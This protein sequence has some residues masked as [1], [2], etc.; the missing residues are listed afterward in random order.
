[1]GRP[2]L[3]RLAFRR[4]ILSFLID[5]VLPQGRVSLLGGVSDVGK[6]SF[7]LPLLLEWEQGKP[8]LSKPSH[9]VPWAYVSGDRLLQDAHDKLNQLGIPKTAIRMIPASGR[10]HKGWL[11]ILFA[12]ARLVPRPE[13]LVVE[14]FSEMC[15]ESRAE[16]ITHLEETGAMCQGCQ[17]F[18]T[19]LTV[20]GIVE[21]PKQKPYE[22]YPNPRQRISGSSAW[23]YK[24]STVLLL[25]SVK[26]D[27]ELLT[28]RRVL[29]V[30][31]KIGKRRKLDAQF[32]AVGR[33]IV[34]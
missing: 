29:Y 13:F 11:S 14:G 15:G 7:I 27:E 20:L 8:V 12:A 30:C 33:L 22:R 31:A 23:G 24:A 25:E 26:G 2:I 32:D 28:D 3:P 4:A 17:E 5:E 10:D 18:P 9:P 16:V 34:P 21:S 6:T 19:G 1:M